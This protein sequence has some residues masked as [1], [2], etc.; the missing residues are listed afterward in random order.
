MTRNEKKN[1]FENNNIREKLRESEERYRTVAD[2]TYDW[3]YWLSPAGKL[4]YVSPSCER[5]SG[6]M[7]EVFIDDPTLLEK[8]ILPAENASIHRMLKISNLSKNLKIV[9]LDFRIVTKDGSILWIN[10][11][12]QPVYNKDN[13]FIGRRA[14]NRDITE[15]KHTE[16]ALIKS[17]LKL[18]K[19]N[20]ELEKKNIALKEVLSQIESEKKSIKD[21][22]QK[23]IEK[24]LLPLLNELK[25]NSNSIDKKCVELI[26]TN[27]FTV[28]N[29]LGGKLKQNKFY[30]LTPKELK[31]CNMI[32]NGFSSK[33][34][35]QFMKISRRTA[36]VHRNNIRRKL[37]LS[38]SKINLVTYLQNNFGL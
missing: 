10:H 15:R 38:N 30:N 28:T 23:N 13:E 3:E 2:F 6:Y 29:S 18:Q 33:E 12:S 26:E 14:S 20:N 17:E 35:S 36:E 24:L 19:K 7:P 37:E 9:N 21:N 22:I 25:T 32:K 31:I 4:L 1:L 5:I 27:I 11:I 16:E 34:I 8:I